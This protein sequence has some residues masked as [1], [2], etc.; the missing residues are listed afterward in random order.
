MWCT[1]VKWCLQFFISKL[2]FLGVASGVGKRAKKKAQNDK[3]FC[4]SCSISQELY[5]IWL[6]F[7]VHK[8]K[9]LISQVFFIFSNFWFF[10][11]V[12]GVRGQKWPRMTKNSVCCAPYLRN[13]RSY[14]HYFWYI[15]VKMIISPGFFFIF[16]KFRFF[17]LL[18]GSKG[19]KWPKTHSVAP[20]ISG[21]MHHM[22]FIY[23]T[24]V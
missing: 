24:H 17:A 9:I 11:I 13:Q 16:S 10:H 12:S 22:I 6:S 14:D 15:N 21:T 3:K 7:V 5:I 20:F 18:G 4:L 8:Y 1:S 2:C 19:K 23:G